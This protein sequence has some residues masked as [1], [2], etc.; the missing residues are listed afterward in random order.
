M[1]FIYLALSILVLSITTLNAQENALSNSTPIELK[2]NSGIIYGTLLVPT[3]IKA[4]IPI[5]LIIAG[6]GPTDRDGNNQMMKNNSLKQLAESLAM[7][8]IAS[9]RYDKRGIAES[10]QAGKSEADLR[11]DDYIQDATDWIKLIK[12]NPLFSKIIVVGHSEGSLIGMNA[13]KFADGFVSL[14]GAGN[15]A[16]IILKN[17]I[18]AQ[19]QQIQDMCFPILDSLKA[20]KTVENIN[21][22]LNNL[23]RPSVQPYMISWFKHNPQADIKQL[24]FPC[25]IIQGDN[26]LQ[27]SIN[28]AKQLADV[29][30]KNNLVIIE[31]MNHV[32]K[33]VDS[34]DRADNIAAYSN[35]SLPIA[36]ALTE[37]IV[38]Y[39]KN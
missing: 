24:K 4:K 37:A 6:S 33:I 39:I 38:K 22:V 20:G 30:K 34:G 29:S 1:K 23:F 14:S 3:D 32:L 27:I 36:T 7:K 5:A 11:F 13:A 2:T 16:D 18:G 19:G 26:D 25:L 9:L 8:G 17:Q 10:K 31:K 28:D 15:S 21:P 12:Q 35:A